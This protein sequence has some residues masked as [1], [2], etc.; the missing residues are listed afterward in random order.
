MGRAEQVI[1]SLAILQAEE[2]W[3]VLF[4]TVGLLIRLFRKHRWEVNFLEARAIH[5]FTNNAFDIAEGD[6][7]KW[8]P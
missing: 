8:Q 6:I 3:P 1:I 5:L 2:I 4:P 7:A